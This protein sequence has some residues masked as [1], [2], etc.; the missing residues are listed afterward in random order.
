[1]GKSEGIR[2]FLRIRPVAKRL[3]PSGAGRE[4]AALTTYA[5]DHT[6]DNSK[7]HFHVDRRAENDVVNNALED[8]RFTFRRAFEPAAT[9]EE[10]FNVVAKDC[11]LAALDGYNSTIFAYGQ[12]GSGKTYSITGGAES[13]NDRGIIPRALA[14]IYDEVARRQQESS[15][16]VAVSYLQIY[17]DRG[18]DLLNHG[19][20]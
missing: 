17:N 18:Q 1:M 2:I 13:Y 16:S 8:Y 19:R 6:F 3:P 5:V 9:Q 11:V 20:D 10:V 7:V 14:L 15:C 12:T 4:D